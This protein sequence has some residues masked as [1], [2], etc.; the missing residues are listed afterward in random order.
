MLSHRATE[1]TPGETEGAVGAA[2]M[3]EHSLISVVVIPIKV[4]EQLITSQGAGRLEPCAA[5]LVTPEKDPL[6]I[7]R[8]QL[9]DS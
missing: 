9:L 7:Q 6:S 5:L 2:V 3:F 1:A 4:Q 8:G